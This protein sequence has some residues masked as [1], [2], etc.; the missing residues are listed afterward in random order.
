[1]IAENS[2]RAS[3]SSFDFSYTR[4]E[5][6]RLET[7]ER[8]LESSIKSLNSSSSCLRRSYTFVYQ[9]SRHTHNSRGPQYF[10]SLFLFLLF[11]LFRLDNPSVIRMMMPPKNY[12]SLYNN[13]KEVGGGRQQQTKE[14][15]GN[16]K[17]R[18]R[19]T[20]KSCIT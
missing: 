10:S 11:L 12:L 8:T 1:V 3:S 17:K 4:R 20:K 13:K 9:E 16:R 14:V 19:G 5:E 18:T 15:E 2:Q 6:R 7:R